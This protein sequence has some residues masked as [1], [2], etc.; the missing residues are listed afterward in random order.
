MVQVV[1]CGILMEE[2]V[3]FY[4]GLKREA[5]DW[6]REGRSLW[7]GR[8]RCL[9]KMLIETGFYRRESKTPE[10]RRTYL[11]KSRFGKNLGDNSHMTR[12]EAE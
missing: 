12:G 4:F 10:S 8:C 5:R 6:L 11:S 2:T 7:N 9:M 3:S 1:A